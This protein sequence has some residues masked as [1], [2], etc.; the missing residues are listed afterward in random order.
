M[1]FKIPFSLR[2]AK[3]TESVRLFL[4]KDHNFLLPFLLWSSRFGVI[5]DSAYVQLAALVSFLIVLF[6]VCNL[7]VRSLDFFDP[8]FV[9]LKSRS[10]VFI[11]FFSSLFTY[12]GLS[13]FD[14]FLWGTCDSTASF[15]TALSLFQSSFAVRVSRLVLIYSRILM[16][17][18]SIPS[19]LAFL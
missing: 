7:V 1:S 3:A 12:G 17:S 10:L 18:I 2:S 14:A 19:Q 13:R 11:I 4:M 8:F 15:R 16:S 5:T 6:K 9:F